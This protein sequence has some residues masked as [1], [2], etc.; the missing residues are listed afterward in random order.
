[1]LCVFRRRS[2]LSI[3]RATWPAPAGQWW[4]GPLRELSGS[5]MKSASRAQQR[6]CFPSGR[7]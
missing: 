3:L 4:A 7:A 1:M 2:S 6:N 5:E